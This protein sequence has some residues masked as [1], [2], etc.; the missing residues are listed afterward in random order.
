MDLS[1]TMWPKTVFLALRCSLGARVM[2]NLGVWVLELVTFVA[3]VVGC[4]QNFLNLLAAVCVFSAVGHAHQACSVDGAP[5][6]V[7]VVELGSVYGHAS[8]SVA[9]GDVAT[10]DHEF[11]DD[12]VEG[13]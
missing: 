12:A 6:D 4:A 10:L 7:F 13:R 1:E 5:A 8:S 3:R 11:I 2:K 9:G